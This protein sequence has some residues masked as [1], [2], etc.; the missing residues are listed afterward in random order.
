MQTAKTKFVQ[1]YTT[2]INVY[3]V[4]CI[5]QVSLRLATHY[6]HVWQCKETM[7]RRAVACKDQD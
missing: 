4:Q 1:G 5:Q 2:Q 3:A 6:V 7:M